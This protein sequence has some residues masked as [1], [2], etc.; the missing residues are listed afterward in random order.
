MVLLVCHRR[1]SNSFDYTCLRRGLAK[2]VTAASFDRI[3]T[4]LDDLYAR[5][6]HLDFPPGLTCHGPA[7]VVGELAVA[8]GAALSDIENA[9]IRRCEAGCLH[10][11]FV[12]L[13]REKELDGNQINDQCDS[14]RKTGIP[15][16]VDSCRHI[17]GHGLAEWFANEGLGA[18]VRCDLF[19]ESAGRQECGRG[20]LM[21]YILGSP[22]QTG[23][24]VRDSDLLE[25]C[26]TLQK[27]YRGTCHEY[28]GFFVFSLSGE[29]RAIA[30]CG[31]V[32][33]VY[34]QGCYAGLGSRAF[35]EYQFD[36]RK[37]VSL[38]SRV[39]VQY[40]DTCVSGAIEIA[41]AEK[42]FHKSGIALCQ[43]LS[44]DQ[45][46]K[47]LNTFFLKLTWAWGE[48][49]AKSFCQ[50]MKMSGQGGCSQTP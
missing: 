29:E 22:A 2:L 4:A 47:C 30:S 24:Y 19:A 36:L 33:D 21:E 13:N 49:W 23:R 43:L 31:R 11:A 34:T 35:W 10:G 12:A 20:F 9:C 39:P 5:R 16:D 6:T 14:F 40:T 26:D 28:A 8:R 45:R 42:Q 3:V 18:I 7:H 15:K 38:C 46:Q 37:L 32:P 27:E 41:A 25:F 44:D 1:S 17:T 48:E 50:T